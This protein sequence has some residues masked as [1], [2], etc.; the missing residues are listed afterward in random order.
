MTRA[1]IIDDEQHCIDRLSKLLKENVAG[2]LQILDYFKTVEDG[3]SGIQ[4]LQ[5]DLV[6]LDVQINDKTGFDLLQQMPSVNFE[7]IFTTAFER[8]AVQ[9]FKFSALDYLLKPVDADDLAAALQKLKEKISAKENNTRFDTLFH[10]LKNIQGISKR[11]CVPVTTGLVFLQVS[12]IIRCQSDI[13]YTTI[14]TKDKQ[15]LVVAKTLKE[16]EEMLS[17]FNFYR[18]HNSHLIN[19]A[20]IKSYNKGKG[21]F[22][23]MTDN[24]DIEV[25]TRRKD[26]FLKRLS[27]M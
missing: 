21:G 4:K 7:V 13:N 18:V 6:F 20:F 25:S 27:D 3:I 17:D 14:F 15:K 26:D 16:F 22:V 2:E 9:A 5:P 12:D 23:T 1:I 19:L 11:I 8:Y 10:N 24:T